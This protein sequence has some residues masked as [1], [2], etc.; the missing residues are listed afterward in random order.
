M[1]IS[2]FYNAD[3][4][5]CFPEL[6]IS[7]FN[8]THRG[9]ESYSLSVADGHTM[10]HCYGD[11]TIDIMNLPR[12]H[13]GFMGVGANRSRSGAKPVLCYTPK[14]GNFSVAFHGYFLNGDK[15]SEELGGESDAVVAARFI[16]R[17][18][19]FL[20]GIKELAEHAVGRYCIAVATEK[21]EAYVAR[22][23]LGTRSLVYGTCGRMHAVASESC[24]LGNDMGII[25]TI[26]PGEIAAVD[27]YGLHTLEKLPAEPK[28]CSFLWAYF[29]WIDAV[30]ESIE[31]AG[32]R[33]K[34]GKMLAV[35]DEE[36]G[37]EAD[38]SAPVPDSGK[39]YAQGYADA[40][41]CGHSEPLVK[42]PYAG[43]SYGRPE[44]SLRDLIAGVKL[45]AVPARARGK[46]IVLCDDSIR[47]GTQ[48]IKK[49][50]PVALLRKAGAKE[51]HLRIGSPRNTHYCRLSR[52]D[53]RGYD[54]NLLAANM[55]KSDEALAGFLRVD[56]VMFPECGEFMRAITED[57]G[58]KPENLCGGCYTGDFGF[59]KKR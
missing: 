44:Q 31:T 40:F 34:I 39:G 17:R 13:A 41:H 3:R 24:G 46:K 30:T 37:L 59:L 42:Y 18:N 35:K 48:L 9:Q 36:R 23:P 6:A 19:D 10:Q 54:D 28:I 8:M 2:L 27:G 43:R 57:S 21:G 55:F 25:R 4:K 26:K 15:M 29:D 33:E 14:Y 53:G 5:N 20:E 45:R 12:N 16:A 49:E 38:I 50:G 52:P 32:V 51:I 22:C 1:A 58:L 47:R 56:S 11:G 7:L